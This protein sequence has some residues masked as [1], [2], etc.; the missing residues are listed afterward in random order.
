[1][2]PSSNL[3]EGPIQ[4][5]NKE[6]VEFL[7]ETQADPNFILNDED[8]T[9]LHFAVGQF[10]NSKSYEEDKS[11]AI[12]K[13]LLEHGANTNAKDMNDNTPLQWMPK[14]HPRFQDLQH[15]FKKYT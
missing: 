13:L 10:L 11:F 2:E 12:I 7:L 15:L 5:K 3:L 8:V 9:L 6:L 4:S 1:M 14:N